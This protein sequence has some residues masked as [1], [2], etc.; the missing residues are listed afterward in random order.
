MRKDIRTMFADSRREP[1]VTAD[2]TPD[3]EFCQQLAARIELHLR[4]GNWPLAARTFRE[5]RKQFELDRVERQH[6]LARSE[7]DWLDA[8]L[9]EL[10]IQARTFNS[11]VNQGCETIRQALDLLNSGKRIPQ[12]GQAASDEVWRAARKLGIT[13][14][15]AGQAEE[16]NHEAQG[17][18]AC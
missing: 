15:R 4:A 7:A 11:L 16:V 1:T 2:E 9:G 12:F 13:L 14:A 6:V 10:E 8:D 3:P 18:R 5:G 17:E